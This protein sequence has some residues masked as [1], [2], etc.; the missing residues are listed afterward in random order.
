MKLSRTELEI[1]GRIAVGNKK[2][3]EIASALNKSR[4][5]IYRSG[6]R[7]VKEGLVTLF[8]GGYE[9]VK[10]TLC[11]LLMQNLKEF[12]SLTKPFSDSG[13]VILSHFVEPR[14]AEELKERLKLSRTQIFKK[15]KQALSIS[16]LEKENGKY[17]LNEK[18]WG[19]AVEFLREL[20][21]YEEN[22][23]SRVPIGSTIY[24]KTEKEIVFSCSEEFNAVPTAFSAYGDYGIKILS[25]IDYYHLPKKKLSKKEVFIHSLYVTEKEKE[26]RN[27]IYSA[28]FYLKH[29]KTLKTVKHYLVEEIK[30][31]LEGQQ[32]PGYPSLREIREKAVDKR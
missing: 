21:G 30:L 2:I 16:L 3:K 29:K 10:T 1:F 7:L 27:L 23:D 8:E 24:Y 14:S 15:I 28:V 31:M 4:S 13:M 6:K 25:P 22:T 18:V 12:P 32:I 5:Q 11:S 17:A 9:P 26:A 19:K 20:K